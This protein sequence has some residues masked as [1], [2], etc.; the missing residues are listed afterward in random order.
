[1]VEN[2]STRSFAVAQ[3]HPTRV[4]H[5]R[6]GKSSLAVSTFALD[7][8]LPPSALLWVF[9]TAAISVV[10]IGTLC[11]LAVLGAPGIVVAM[12]VFAAAAIP[13]S[14]GA[15][16]LQAMPPFSTTNNPAVTLPS[17]PSP[18]PSSGSADDRQDTP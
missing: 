4:H 12:L 1:M 5:R 16:P 17:S 10:G 9:G 11:V 6:P 15:I 13:T 2:P 14:G 8:D 18:A 3:A 7:L